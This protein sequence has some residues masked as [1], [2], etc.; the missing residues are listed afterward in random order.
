MA[1][2]RRYFFRRENRVLKRRDYLDAYENGRM[3]KRRA[4]RVF[5]LAR[6]PASLPTRLGITASSKVGGAVQRN[7]LKRIAREVFRLALP[8]LRPGYTLIV[9]YHRAAVEMDSAQIREQLH[10]IWR[11]AGLSRDDPAGD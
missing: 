11:E 5:V 9:N 6:E 2:V 8:D 10:S 1:A 3:Y 4:A 7:R